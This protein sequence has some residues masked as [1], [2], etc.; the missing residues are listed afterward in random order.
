MNRL[1]KSTSGG[2]LARELRVAVRLVPC[3]LGLVLLLSA[4]FW[5]ADLAAT[6][7]LFQS[8]Q[9]T[10]TPEPSA[11][12]SLFQSPQDTP[13]PEPPTA[14]PVETPVVVPEETEIVE[15]TT[16]PEPSETPEPTATPTEPP[17]PTETPLPPTD[18]PLPPPTN[19]PEPVAT[20]DR[21]RYAEDEDNLRFEWGMLFDSLAL[22]LAYI[23]LFCGFVLFVC[24]GGLLVVVWLVA[25][26]RQREQGLSDEG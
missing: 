18:T 1:K 6:G 22:G 12:D 13:T 24:I 26:R 21:G 9:D 25:R 5:R 15:P 10:P 16:P 11:R 8:P 4:F 3:F 20:E 19:T 14:T 7:G 2:R 17:T 23:W